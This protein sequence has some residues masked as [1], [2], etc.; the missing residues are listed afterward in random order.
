MSE[1]AKTRKELI[2]WALLYAP[3]QGRQLA[4]LAMLV[5][6]LKAFCFQAEA[7]PHTGPLLT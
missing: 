3:N 1:E 4:S 2:Y 7:A 5:S 6:L